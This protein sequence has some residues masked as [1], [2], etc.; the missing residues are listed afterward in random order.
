LENKV[1]RLTRNLETLK[2]VVEDLYAKVEGFE[3]QMFHLS[4]STMTTALEV[5]KLV[6]N[7]ARKS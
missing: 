3:R 1:N 2:K 7:K 5:D 4:N 6:K